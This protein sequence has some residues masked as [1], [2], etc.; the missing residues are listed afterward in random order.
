MQEQQTAQQPSIVEVL[1]RTTEV[2]KQG[3]PRKK[4][5]DSKP[6]E[7]I[8]KDLQPLSVVEDEGFITY[9]WELDKRYKPPTRANLRTVLLP[10][11]FERVQAI[12]K[13]DLSSVSHV[14]LTTDLWSSINNTGF[15][16]TCGSKRASWRAM[17]WYARECR[18]VTQVRSLQ[19]CCRGLWRTMASEASHLPS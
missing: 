3:S 13:K 4:A 16:A 15:M 2:Y 9:S 12:V 19:R 6:T 10:S 5:I 11:L 14:S 18:E 17:F 7:M 1:T 8:V